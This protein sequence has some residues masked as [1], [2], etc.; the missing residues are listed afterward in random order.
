MR[1][2]SIAVLLAAAALVGCAN[3]PAQVSSGS[4]ETLPEVV[5]EAGPI[6]ITSQEMV[7]AMAGQEYQLRLQLHQARQDWIQSE[8]GERMV[9]R[10]AEK[11]GL[12]VEGLLK[13]IDAQAKVSTDTDA[14]MFYK[15]QAQQGRI[16]DP[17]TGK[18]PEFAE[19]KDRIKKHLD[20]QAKQGAR[21]AYFGKVM[22]GNEPKVNLVLPDPP[23][24][25]GVS[26]E[27]DPAQGPADAKVTIVEFSDFQCPACKQAHYKMPALLEKY[28]DKIKFVYRDFPLLGKHEDALPAAVAASCAGDQGKYWEMHDMLFKAPS[29]KESDFKSF[30]GNLK[31]DADKFSACLKEPARDAE[32]RKD[33]EDG[34]AYGVNSTPTFYVNGY[35]VVGANMPEI[36]RLIERELGKAGAGS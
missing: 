16:K 6:K 27:D 24:I 23:F 10:E 8:I 17:Q 4:G 7:N 30:A 11:E 26:P 35:L 12:D 9:K 34:R 15:V 3:P 5:A 31:L 18:V 22:E 1:R 28:G 33:L 25:A 20:D 36:T 14:Q 13:K 32:V 19:L 21:Q 2:L 29:L